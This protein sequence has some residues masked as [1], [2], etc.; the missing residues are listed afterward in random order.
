ADAAGSSGAQPVERPFDAGA[1]DAAPSAPAAASG[2]GLAAGGTQPAP[3]RGGGTGFTSSFDWPAKLLLER[4]GLTAGTA[5]RR[6]EGRR[7]RSARGCG[8]P[9]L[10]R[11]DRIGKHADAREGRRSR[12]E[13]SVPEA[14][15]GDGSGQGADRGQPDADRYEAA[16]AQ[17]AASARTVDREGR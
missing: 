14:A 3:A 1:P 8:L 16:L 2:G 9:K 15:S 4:H 12:A 17:R 7:T 11:H 6:G 10:G 5:Q 13:L